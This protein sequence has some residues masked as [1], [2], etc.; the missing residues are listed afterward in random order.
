M[1][2]IRWLGLAALLLG[3]RGLV[4]ERTADDTGD[5]GAGAGSVPATTLPSTAG[6][7]STETATTPPTVDTGTL[8]TG[9][10]DTGSP[11]ATSGSTGPLRPIDPGDGLAVD[12]DGGRWVTPAVLGALAAELFTQWA[13]IG[14]TT[15][16]D[17][18][19]FLGTTVPHR[20][21]QDLCAPTS[22]PVAPTWD[23]DRFTL[24][25]E[26]VQIWAADVPL[27]VEWLV[28]E[29]RIDGTG[30]LREG[31]LHGVADLKDVP[32]PVGDLCSFLLAL[33]ERCIPCADGRVQCAEVEITDLEGAPMAD[34]AVQRSPEAVDADPSCP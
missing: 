10:V 3:C 29:G 24:R 12:L 11:G 16:P 13:V 28:V 18:A 6:T 14:A 30:A 1:R 9:T 32:S 26:G 27:A 5:G 20:T 19:L 17:P 31:H 7:H 25:A 22:S 33:G 2:H 4:L 8:D 21:T 15:D 34:G 23:G